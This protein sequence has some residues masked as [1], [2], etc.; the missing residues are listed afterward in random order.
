MT[1]MAKMM[2][3]LGAILLGLGL[4]LYFGSRMDGSLLSWFGKLPGDIRIKKENF[5]FYF[6]LTTS[7]LVSVV[8]SLI[9]YLVS[10]FR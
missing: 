9:L 8:L 4:L 1:E 10:R 5:S 3:I 7:I 6:P 2:M